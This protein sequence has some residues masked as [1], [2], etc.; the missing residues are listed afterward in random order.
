MPISSAI[1]VAMKAIASE[2]WPPASSRRSRRAAAARP[3]RAPATRSLPPSDVLPRSERVWVALRDR[4]GSASGPCPRSLREDRLADETENDH[5]SSPIRAISATRSLRKRQTRPPP[6]VAANARPGAAPGV[7]HRAEGRELPP[8]R[9]SVVMSVSALTGSSP[10]VAHCHPVDDAARPPR[11]AERA[12][13]IERH[14]HRTGTRRARGHVHLDQHLPFDQD[15]PAD[16]TVA[17]E[18]EAA[19]AA[20]GSTTT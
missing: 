16:P 19:A 11:I 7:G 15:L 4:T 18:D 20:A 5:E 10:G 17:G 13:R 2:T 3:R 14:E 9:A 6:L 12:V 1:S 8:E